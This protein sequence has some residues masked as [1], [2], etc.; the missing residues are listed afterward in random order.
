LMYFVSHVLRPCWKTNYPQSYEDLT[1]QGDAVVACIIA[2]DL[3]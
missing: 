1:E 2:L 3:W